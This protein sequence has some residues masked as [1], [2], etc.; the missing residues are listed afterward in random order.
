M[1]GKKLHT[2]PSYI[3]IISLNNYTLQNLG[4]FSITCFCLYQ[5]PSQ[6]GALH[7][8]YENNT[9]F[10]HYHTPEKSAH[11]ASNVLSLSY[12]VSPNPCVNS[13][14]AS[15]S[16]RCKIFSPCVWGSARWVRHSTGNIHSLPASFSLHFYV[17]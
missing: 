13:T 10:S 16:H 12:D 5:Y 4:K 6:T 2:E 17:F 15:G 11:N 9:S 8:T 14:K 1:P 3:C 7:S